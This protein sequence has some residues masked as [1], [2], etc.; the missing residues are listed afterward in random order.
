[1]LISDGAVEDYEPVFE[2]YNWP[3]RKVTSAGGERGGE[4]SKGMFLHCRGWDGPEKQAC[5][6]FKCSASLAPLVNSKS[7]SPIG[8][9]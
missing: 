8:A 2:K 9:T 4:G 5:S 1:M 7:M 3:D 6:E